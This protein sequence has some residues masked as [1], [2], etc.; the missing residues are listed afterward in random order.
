MNV[1]LCACV[2]V[3]SLFENDQLIPHVF[4]EYAECKKKHIYDI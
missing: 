3:N 1:N 4:H 2:G